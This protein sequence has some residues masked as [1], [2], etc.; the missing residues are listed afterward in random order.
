MSETLIQAK[1][2]PMLFSGPMI[3]ALLDG[4]K[5]QTRRV[6]KWPL[7]ANTA[8]SYGENAI[9]YGR[10][11]HADPTADI[12]R[13]CPYGQP[14]D[15][16][17]VRETCRAEEAPHGIDGIR[18]IA[19]DFWQPIKNTV[20][21]AEQWGKMFNYRRVRGATVPPIHMPRWASRLLLEI[22]AVRVERLQHISER[23]VRAEGCEMRQFN[24]LFMDAAERKRAYTDLYGNLWVSING[25]ESWAANPW[26]WVVEFKVIAGGKEVASV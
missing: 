3:R 26:V 10:N 19:D 13:L 9:D 15:R 11:H 22:K 2:R 4:S 21:A 7:K 1:E 25:P 24:L 23:D 18:Y 14:G 12:I 16:L 5:T 8:V 17:W 20:E 6:V